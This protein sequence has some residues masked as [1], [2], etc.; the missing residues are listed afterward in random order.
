MESEISTMRLEA[1]MR[2][3]RDKSLIDE[4]CDK[5]LHAED[6]HTHKLV[7]FVEALVKSY[8]LIV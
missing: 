3:S 8:T 6:V 1:E 7:S 4:I 2:S 5:T